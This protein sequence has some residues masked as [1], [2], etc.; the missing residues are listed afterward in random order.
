MSA[1]ETKRKAV[2]G[3]D[4]RTNEKKWSKE[5]MDAGWTVFPTVIIENQK[6]LGLDP[7]D[8]NILLHLASRWWTAAGKPYPSK[9]SI[10]NA[11][12]REPRTVQ[13]RVA[14]MEAAGYVHREQRRATPT[15]SKP[16][17]YHL[18][19]L[20]E[21]AKPFA[22]EK[23]AEI[24]AKAAAAK[25]KAERKGAPKKKPLFKVVRGDKD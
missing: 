4:L 21:A 14:R 17:I 10:A 18:E 8:V 13:R 24:A 6:Q 25:A 22:E 5:L 20:I 16:N 19:G 7:L 11:V 3:G 12:G 15:G 2:A 9:G 23:L 1:D